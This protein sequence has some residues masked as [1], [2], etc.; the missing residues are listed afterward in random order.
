MS[1]AKTVVV[2]KV[3]KAAMKIAKPRIKWRNGGRIRSIGGGMKFNVGSFR[4]LCLQRIFHDNTGL[5]QSLHERGNRNPHPIQQSGHL[6]AEK[7]GHQDP[8]PPAIGIGLLQD[9]IAVVEAIE[10]LRQDEGVFGQ[11]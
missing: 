8:S 10:L 7:V 3:H 9:G 11:R 2:P 1:S 6:P 4:Q 5:R